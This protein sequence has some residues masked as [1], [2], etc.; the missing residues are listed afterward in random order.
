[1]QLNRRG[2]VAWAFSIALLS[3]G[4]ARADAELVV[5]GA[6]YK[7]RSTRVVQPMLDARFDVGASGE[8]A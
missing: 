1:M 8:I 4:V 2:A 3:S 7:E 6:Y 5:S